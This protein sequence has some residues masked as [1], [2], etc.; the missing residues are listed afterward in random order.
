MRLCV[1][2]NQ[3]ASV[4]AWSFELETDHKPLTFLFSEN[5]GI[6]TNASSCVQRW[7]LML[8]SYNYTIRY[9]P[10]T[11]N[12]GDA[13]SRLPVPFTDCNNT[14]QPADLVLVIYVFESN[15]SP[16]T[17]AQVRFWSNRDPVLSAVK[18]CVMTGDWS[19]ILDSEEYK[20]YLCCRDELSVQ[21]ECL[22][23]GRR[24]IMP[25]QGREKL[26]SELHSTHPGSV[27]MKAIARSHVWW[28]GIDS[29]LESCV[30]RCDTCMQLSKSPAESP[31]SLWS[32]PFKPWSRIHVDFAGLFF[33]KMFLV[34]IDAFSKCIECSIMST[35]TSA[36]TIENLRVMFTTHGLDDVLVSDNGS[37][38][39]CQE[40]QEFMR[41]NGI[42]H[43]RS[44]PFKLASNG[45]VD[46]AVQ[47]IKQGLR[48][49]TQG[50]LQTCLSRVLLG[51]RSRPHTVTGVS[52]AK[53]LM[54]RELKTRLSLVHPD[55]SE[56]VDNKRQG[57][58]YDHDCMVALHDFAV[59]DPVYVLNHGLGVKWL[60]GVFTSKEGTRVFCVK[61]K[62]GHTLRKR[63]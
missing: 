38:F 19:C 44:A 6:N 8:S 39:T 43:V 53:L 60:P 7:A 20:P 61:L 57:Q 17:A 3:D 33:G 45:Q 4:F 2:D 34:V 26:V 29:E 35:S 63:G 51:Y 47:I 55:I 10:G 9:R 18:H 15:N 11:G 28:P 1:W 40:F 30:H 22:L 42:K 56:A 49:V 16:V 41:L 58:K 48:R 23:W 52:P 32:W 59:N 24:V 62:D 21:S 31:L 36:A 27:T 12:C 5:K 14:P 54:K 25:K 37:C 13:L 50:A 46:R